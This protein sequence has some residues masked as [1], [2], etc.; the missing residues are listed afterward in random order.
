MGKGDSD[1]VEGSGVLCVWLMGMLNASV[2][3]ARHETYGQ[4]L[5]QC[6][7]TRAEKRPVEKTLLNFK[8]EAA[9]D[10]I[11]PK[12]CRADLN[13]KEIN[14]C[15]IHNRRPPTSKQ[16]RSAQFHAMY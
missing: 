9:V 5:P 3:V 12:G 16:L 10:G 8:M 11:L 2:A 13:Q 15:W 7:W 6:A 1:C 14:D 4:I